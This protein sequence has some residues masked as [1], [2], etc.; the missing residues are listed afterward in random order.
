MLGLRSFYQLIA[1]IVVTSSVA[2]VTTGLTS[3]IAALQTQKLRFWVPFT[4]GATGG[5]RAIVAVPAGGTIFE[6]TIKLFNTVAPSL[7]T[8]IQNGSAAFTNALANAGSHWLEIE[9]VV[10]NGATAGNVDLQ[11]AQNTSDVLS[12]TILR[13]GSVDVVKA[14]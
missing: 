11:M 13:G 12:L 6:A 5:V 2:P 3:P 9:V 14:S 4:V 7:T 10:V 8:S 1:N